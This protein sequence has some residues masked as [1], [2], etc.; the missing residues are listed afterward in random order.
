MFETVEDLVGAV[1]GVVSPDGPLGRLTG[2][3]ALTL[4]DALDSVW[5]GFFGAS[6]VSGGTNWN[7]YSHQQL[8][9]MIWRDADVQEVSAVAAEWGRHSVALADFADGL[10]REGAALRSNWQGRAAGLAADRLDELSDRIWNAGARAGTVQ[11]ATSEAGD[12]LVLA[13][14]TMPPPPPDPMTIATSAVGAGPLSPVQ[15]VLVGGMRVFTADAVA[16]ASKADAVRAMRRYE[17]SLASSANQVVPAG[18]DATTARTYETGGGP[19]SSTSPAAVTGG[20]PAGG[21]GGGGGVPWSRLVGGSPGGG[22]GGAPGPGGLF[23][24]AP[25]PVGRVLA[26]ESAVRSDAVRRGLGGGFM[27][28]AMAPMRGEEDKDKPHQTRLPTVDSGIFAVGER[29]SA[30]VIG[31]ATDRENGVGL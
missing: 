6:T 1:T 15:A 4:T 21:P 2:T 9:D 28:P 14:N 11:Q 3:L 22:G 23:G 5:A 31:A 10:R 27:G 29:G 18:A 25:G 16:G 20:G 13:R 8:Y 7:A 24:S 17:S 26:A 30:A 19:G 12:A